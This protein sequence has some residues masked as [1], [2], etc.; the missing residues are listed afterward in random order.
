[1]TQTNSEEQ[2]RADLAP[3]RDR[4]S[5]EDFELSVKD[6][7]RARDRSLVSTPLVSALS[8]MKTNLPTY[9]T[10]EIAPFPPRQYHCD[11]CE[12]ARYVL[13]AE[14]R[15]DATHVVRAGAIPCPRCV[16]LEQRAIRSGVDARFVSARLD[17]MQTQPGNEAALKFARDWDGSQSVLITPRDR[18]GDSKWGTGKTMLAS[19]MLIGQIAKARAGRFLY[20]RDFL[21]GIQAQFG[22]DSG[23][24][25]GYID[26][27][28]NEPLLVLDDLGAERPT[29]WAVEQVRTLFDARYRK[30]L[31]TIVTTNFGSH[32]EIA[33]AIG[34]AIASRLR[35]YAWVKVGGAD[36]RGS[37]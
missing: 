3:F 21:S 34:G 25:Q 29:D 2:V 35:E 16:P 37:R 13:T 24:V 26:L 20:V 28:A 33:D 14:R 17:T 9:T 36:L 8:A 23:A 15:L 31:T 27:I 5:A 19:A 22:S 10:T 12:D 11:A 6:E 32:A 4:L 1:M 30:Q 18:A 7:L